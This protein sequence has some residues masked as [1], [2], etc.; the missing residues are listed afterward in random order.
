MESGRWVSEPPKNVRAK[1]YV[2]LE[3]DCDNDRV[4]DILGSFKL[5]RK[6]YPTDS[7]K[8]LS[9]VRFLNPM[10]AANAYAITKTSWM[11]STFKGGEKGDI[12]LTTLT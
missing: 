7:R 3:A 5:S 9:S 12:V 10:L 4:R 1:G 2:M 6:N 11:S 8:E